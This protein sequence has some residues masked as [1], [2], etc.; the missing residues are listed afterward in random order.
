MLEASDLCLTFTASAGK[1]KIKEPGPSVLL[2]GQSKRRELK[3]SF[4]DK[5]PWR[6][7]YMNDNTAVEDEKCNVT[8]RSISDKAS[9]TYCPKDKVKKIIDDPLTPKWELNKATGRCIY[10]A[11][12]LFRSIYPMRAPDSLKHKVEKFEKG[13]REPHSRR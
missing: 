1:K 5:I 10:M 3:V 12:Q 6:T 4:N 8:V 13:K 9:K 7:V 2:R 11:A